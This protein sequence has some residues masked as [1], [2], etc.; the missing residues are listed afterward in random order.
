MPPTAPAMGAGASPRKPW[1]GWLNDP[2]MRALLVRT[3]DGA[4]V[5]PLVRI[6]AKAAEDMLRFA[7]EF[8]LTP[9][10]RARIAGGVGGPPDDG[11]FAGLFGGGH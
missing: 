3:A 9:I 1:R 10:A 4:K 7:S 6:A 11:K 8:G 2:A 5:N